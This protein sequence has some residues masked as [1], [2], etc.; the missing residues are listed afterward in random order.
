MTIRKANFRDV[1]SLRAGGYHIK[2]ADHLFIIEEDGGLCGAIEARPMLF[3]E[4]VL[5]VDPE[6]RQDVF[7]TLSLTATQAMAKLSVLVKTKDEESQAMLESLRFTHHKMHQRKL[8]VR[9]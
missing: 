6:K 3:I 8:F 5:Y 1:A 7:D 2:N 9:N 4:N